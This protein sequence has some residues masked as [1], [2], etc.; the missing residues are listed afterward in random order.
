MTNKCG[1]LLEDRHFRVLGLLQENPE[2]SQGE[3]AAA[4]GMSARG[5]ASLRAECPERNRLIKLGNFSAAENKRLCAC[6][7]AAK[8]II[9]KA[10]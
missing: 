6:V 7:L 10:A 8:G 2:L 5:G 9:L 1:K 4:V 3:L